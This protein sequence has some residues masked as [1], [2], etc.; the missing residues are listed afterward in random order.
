MAPNP[1]AWDKH[2]PV[3]S[4]SR[5]TLI[6]DAIGHLRRGVAVKVIGG[7]GMGKSVLLQQIATPIEPEARVIRVS[8][9]PEEATVA[10]AVTDLA[11]KLGIRDLV[12]PRMDDLLE[13]T[14]Q[15]DVTRLVVLFDET[16]QYIAL[17]GTEGAFARA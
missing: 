2:F 14:W 8:S 16:D 1:Y 4:V 3:R 9:P 6:A 17:G 11:A 7:R 13:R 15:G 5:G 12:P 10:G